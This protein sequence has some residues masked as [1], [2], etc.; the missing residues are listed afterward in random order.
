V[1]IYTVLMD[2]V[3]TILNVHFCPTFNFNV[4]QTSMY[5]DIVKGY[6][7]G[8]G[9]TRF[10]RQSTMVSATV[11]SV[12]TEVSCSCPQPLQRRSTFR[13]NVREN[14]EGISRERIDRLRKG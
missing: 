7:N 8:M 11:F 9:S 6:F 4:K 1:Y 14:E 3:R 12:P 5:I 2:K 10:Q 13:Y